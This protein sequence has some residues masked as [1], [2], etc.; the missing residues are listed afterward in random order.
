MGRRT[1]MTD[2]S[3]SPS[4][5]GSDALTPAITLT[6]I[7]SLS[8]APSP[9]PQPVPLA[10][11][12]TLPAGALPSA[13]LPPIRALHAAC[14]PKDAADVG[15]LADAAFLDRIAWLHDAGQCVWV[16]CWKGC[17]PPAAPAGPASPLPPLLAMVTATPYPTSLFGFNLAVAPAWRG[18]GL[19][20]RVM[21]ELQAAALHR[22][23]LPAISATVDAAG[24]PSLVRYYCSFGGE[25][26]ATGVSGA[27]AGPPP[28]VRVVRRFDAGGL[29]KA[30][31]EA[32]A[33]FVGK[34]VRMRQRQALA[35]L[36]GIVVGV[37][38]LGVVGWRRA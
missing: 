2:T 26:E 32:D 15:G 25:V 11:L 7:P 3:P 37:V 6:P 1:Q 14:F 10:T 19:G 13:F 5:R 38:G 24:S 27:G 20:R 30:I 31:A 12:Q 16:L 34:V 29:R 36:V 17:A 35:R 23:A 22:F 21:H 18:A 4:W 28:T 9:S 33:A 8:M